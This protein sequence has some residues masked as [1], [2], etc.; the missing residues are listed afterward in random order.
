M[1]AT[2]VSLKLQVNSNLNRCRL[3]SKSPQ[4]L[5]FIPVGTLRNERQILWALRN[6]PATIEINIDLKFK[7]YEGGVHIRSCVGGVEGH[8]VTLVGYNLKDKYW[9]VKNSWGENWEESGYMKLMMGI[10]GS[11]ELIPHC[12]HH[13]CF[14]W[15]NISA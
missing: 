10:G 14:R 15:W 3:V 9:I 5:S 6:Q 12:V 1:N 8:A 2:L 11:C 13:E 4:D 7:T